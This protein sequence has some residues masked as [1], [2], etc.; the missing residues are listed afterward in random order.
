M[1]RI[2]TAISLNDRK[3]S[4]LS[5]LSFCLSRYCT[6]TH[7]PALC[8]MPDTEVSEMECINKVQSE[9]LPSL[10]QREE[11]ELFIFL[12]PLF[13]IISKTLHLYKA[14]SWGQKKPTVLQRY[15]LQPTDD[16]QKQHLCCA[17]DTTSVLQAENR[18]LGEALANTKTGILS[19]LFFSTNET[20]K[21]SITLAQTD[22]GENDSLI[23]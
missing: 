15:K 2:T 1:Q 20:C 14:V 23:N 6:H 22:T 13:L 3:I 19:F 9:P 18:W 21:G 12:Y 11:K 7:T 4:S 8:I 5:P 10:I 17:L 16:K